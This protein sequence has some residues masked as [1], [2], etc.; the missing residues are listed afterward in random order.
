[1]HE[2]L[3]YDEEFDMDRHE[4]YVVFILVVVFV[5]LVVDGIDWDGVL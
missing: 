3:K 2:A 1:M 5:V 4:T